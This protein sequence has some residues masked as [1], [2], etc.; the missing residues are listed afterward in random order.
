MKRG[1]SA[2]ER[3]SRGEDL[4]EETAK[5][6]LGNGRKCRTQSLRKRKA[7]GGTGQKGIVTQGRQV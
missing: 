6:E 5:S 3:A 4:A 7:P 1:K 2:L